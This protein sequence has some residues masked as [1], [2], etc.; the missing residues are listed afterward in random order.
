MTSSGPIAFANGHFIRQEQLAIPLW[1][2]GFVWGATVTDLCRTVRDRLYRWPNRWV[3]MRRR[4]HSAHI[5][6]AQGDAEVSRLAEELVAHNVARL[7]AEQALALLLLA[8]P[9]PI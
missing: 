5:A 9:G 7:T 4:G 2:A 6:R 3:P 1:D 8:T